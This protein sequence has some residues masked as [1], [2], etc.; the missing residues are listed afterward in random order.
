MSK[1]IENETLKKIGNNIKTSR[2]LKNYTQE[3][4][5]EK[6]NKSNNFVS[7][8]ERGKSGLGIETIIDICNILD[9]EPNTL[10]NGLI[11][12]KNN[13]DKKIIN[14][15]SSLSNEDKEIVNNL[16]TYILNKN[17]K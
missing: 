12:Y 13:K 6:L 1:N 3:Y 17:S 11:K 9:I 8:I 16:I 5:A 4:L 2:V 15:I 10:F 14:S 7:L